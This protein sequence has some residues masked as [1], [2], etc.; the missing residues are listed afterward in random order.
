MQTT[1]RKGLV[2]GTLIAISIL[3]ISVEPLEDLLHIRTIPYPPPPYTMFILYTYLWRASALTLVC[4]V[5]TLIVLYVRGRSEFIQGVLDAELLLF[6][7]LHYLYLMCIVYTFHTPVKILPFTYTVRK[8][9]HL[10][11]GQIVILYF[12]IRLIY[13]KTRSKAKSQARGRTSQQYRKSLAHT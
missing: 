8:L 7:P 6:I 5:L 11:I 2:A 10:D 4:A 13:L 12:V 9:P 1:Y 3:L